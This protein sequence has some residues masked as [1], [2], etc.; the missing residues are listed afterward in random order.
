M[1]LG[2]RRADRQEGE[3]QAGDADVAADL[4]E[5]PAAPVGRGDVEIVAE[6]GG[7]EKTEQVLRRHR[8]GRG[9]FVQVSRGALGVGAEFHR[10]EELHGREEERESERSG[11]QAEAA[12]ATPGRFESDA[13]GQDEDGE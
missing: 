2:M 10:G 3:H 6:K 7:G 8:V 9:K 1:S 11:S 13:R 4:P 5:E 12:H